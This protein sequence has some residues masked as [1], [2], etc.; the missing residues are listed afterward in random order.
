MLLSQEKT[1]TVQIT[2]LHQLQMMTIVTLIV[3]A[4]HMKNVLAM[5]I[6]ATF[7]SANLVAPVLPNRQLLHPVRRQNPQ[8]PHHHHRQSLQLQARPPIARRLV[9]SKN[10]Q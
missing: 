5:D 7:K 8:H 3:L 2:P 10:Q 9:P 6:M 1:A 4:I